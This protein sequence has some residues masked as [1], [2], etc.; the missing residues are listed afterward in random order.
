MNNWAINPLPIS[1]S[2]FPVNQI[3]M[4]AARLRLILLSSAFGFGLLP[5]GLAQQNGNG[6][7]LPCQSVGLWN[8]WGNW[9]ACPPA[10]SSP[11]MS[12]P[13]P[14]VQ[15]RMRACLPQPVGCKPSAPFNCS[16]SYS[17]VRACNSSSSPAAAGGLPPQPMVASSVSGLGGASFVGGWSASMLQSMQIGGSQVAGPLN[18]GMLQSMQINAT[19]RR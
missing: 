19:G 7:S 13:F 1:Y 10:S 15:R 8:N 12:L 2:S 14:N 9:S 5:L 3:M 6:S 4:A 16:G 17:E 18:A 11:V